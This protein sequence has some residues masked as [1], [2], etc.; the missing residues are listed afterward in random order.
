MLRPCSHI[1]VVWKPLT[2]AS[3]FDQFT[4]VKFVDPK[5]LDLSPG[6]RMIFVGDI[7]GSYDPLQRLMSE[8]QYDDINDV[9][10]HVGDLVAKGPKPEQV[11]QWMREHKIRGVRGNHDQPVIQWRTWMEW[12]GGVE[13]E[14]YM[15]LLSGKEGDEA[16]QILDKDKKKYP[17]DWI[18]KG[19]HWN[20]ARWVT[21]V[22]SPRFYLTFVQANFKGIIRVPHQS[23]AHPSLAFYSCF[24]SPR[25][26]SPLEPSQIFIRSLPTTC[27][28]FQQHSLPPI[29]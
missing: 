6:H 20:I 14:A 25:R 28:I 3:D 27:R 5:D 19:E 4:M 2:K 12:A 23:F 15:D 8:L 9:L 16:I 7:H 26:S 22:Y 1:A 24:R 10:F 11:L 17:D 21:V 13:W 29:P 18:W